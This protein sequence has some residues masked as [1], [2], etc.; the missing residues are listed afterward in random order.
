MGKTYRG[1]EKERAA[2]IA[3]YRQIKRNLKTATDADYRK[4]WERKALLIKE[5]YGL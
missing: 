3:E 4:T 5:E 2:A 1:K